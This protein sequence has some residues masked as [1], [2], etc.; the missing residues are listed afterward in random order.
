[1]WN[2]TCKNE[3]MAFKRV[4]IVQGACQPQDYYRV[5]GHDITHVL[6]KA[7]V[8][9]QKPGSNIRQWHKHLGLFAFIPS[10]SGGTKHKPP[11]DKTQQGVRRTRLT[12]PS[13]AAVVTA[14]SSCIEMFL[15]DA[16]SI[17]SGSVG[18]RGFPMWH[19]LPLHFAPD[20]TQ[21][22]KLSKMG[23]F[24]YCSYPYLNA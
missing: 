6:I 3:N 4:G 18:W 11:N 20:S 15:S 12:A 5:D 10:L 14:M 7:K 19:T 2:S 17:S 13:E 1:M 21:W 8:L 9:E 23:M 22:N 24:K 16:V